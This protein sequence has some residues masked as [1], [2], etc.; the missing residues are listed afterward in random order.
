VQRERVVPLTLAL[1][2]TLQ[3][4][5][6]PQAN[7]TPLLHHATKPSCPLFTLTPRR[8][9]PTTIRYSLLHDFNIRASFSLSPPRPCR[10]LNMPVAHALPEGPPTFALIYGYPAGS[11]HALRQKQCP[12]SGC[13]TTLPRCRRRHTRR[14]SFTFQASPAHRD[15][16]EE[17]D[18]MV[19]EE[20]PSLII[21]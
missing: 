20:P 9:M 4:H 16:S 10:S 17:E 19:A 6:C 15:A 8:H 11:A 13:A 21:A 14:L 1:S 5:V 2:A 12:V 7:R 3:K 18:I